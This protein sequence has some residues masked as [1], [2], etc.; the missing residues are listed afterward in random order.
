V[1]DERIECHWRE[2]SWPHTDYENLF[3]K[4]L[5]RDQGVLIGSN[6]FSVDWGILRNALNHVRF[7]SHQLITCPLDRYYWPID[8]SL[9]CKHVTIKEIGT[10]IESACSNQFQPLYHSL[11]GQKTAINHTLYN[12]IVMHHLNH[13]ED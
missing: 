10:L 8:T 3:N 2:K 12:E 13:N 11:P 6:I 7:F 1:L 5:L 9:F 4:P